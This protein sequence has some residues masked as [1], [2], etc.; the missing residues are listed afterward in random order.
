MPPRVSDHGRR[1]SRAYLGPVEGREK[2]FSEHPDP[3]ECLAQANQ[4]LANQNVHSSRQF[5]RRLDLIERFILRRYPV[6]GLSFDR[7]LYNQVRAQVEGHKRQIRAL[8]RTEPIAVHPGR[9]SETSESDSSSVE[10]VGRYRGLAREPEDLPTKPHHQAAVSSTQVVPG[11]RTSTTASKPKPAQGDPSAA[12][13]P[14][15]RR[16]EDVGIRT[17]VWEY[18]RDKD[19][20][21]EPEIWHADMPAILPFGE[22]IYMAK[23]ES[24]WIDA[25]LRQNGAGSRAD[26][27]ADQGKGKGKATEV[28]TPSAK[29]KERARFTQL[30]EGRVIRTS[31]P[32]T[33][34]PQLSLY[35]S[36]S[37]FKLP[38]LREGRFENLESFTKYNK[39]LFDLDSVVKEFNRDKSKG[40]KDYKP[41]TYAPRIALPVFKEAKASKR[42]S[43][44]SSSATRSRKTSQYDELSHAS[45]LESASRSKRKASLAAEEINKRVRH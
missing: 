36:G 18:G 34:Q 8:E 42:A 32:A 31:A 37:R 4:Y 45:P 22:T 10:E 13:R 7:R 29:G 11:S 3:N 23:V 43:T 38:S 26:R 5:E 39:G 20:P 30:E 6:E 41:N 1:L 21:N 17:K 2:E 14:H 27:T 24:D 35:D 9:L 33:E 16:R 12:T 25:D 28:A 15:D 19:A 40:G 44:G